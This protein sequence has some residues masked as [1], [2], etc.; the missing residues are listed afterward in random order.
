[1]KET[2]KPAI[3][4]KDYSFWYEH[5]LEPTLEHC[6]FTLNYGE[7]VV[8]AGLSGEGKSTLMFSA[9]GV[10]PNFIPGTQKGDILVQ[11]ESIIGKKIASVAKQVGSVLQNAES[12]I[13]HEKVEDEIAF[14]CEN[15]GIAS[16]NIAERVNYG[17]SLMDLD[18]LEETITL[19]GG[20]KQRLITATT[21]AMAQR[22]VI[23]D[24]PF[25]NID[26]AGAT[27]LL[28]TLRALADK[29]YAVL[30]VEHR[31]DTV[32]PYADRVMW[33]EQRGLRALASGERPDKDLFV[34][35][36]TFDTGSGKTVLRLQDATYTIKEKNILRDLTLAIKDGERIVI[37]GENG[38]GK[39]TLLRL[40]ARLINT[41]SGDYQ[42]HILPDRTKKPK[43]AWFRTVGFVYQNPNYQLFMPT[44]ESE[45]RYQA[46]DDE[47]AQQMLE[48]F[49]LTALS[50]Q[51]P[52]SLSEGQK[53]KLSLAAIMATKPQLLLLDEPTVGQDYGGLAMI[54]HNLELL[55]RETRGAQVVVTHDSRCAK[56]M[57]DRVIWMKQGRIYR[58]GPSSLCDEYFSSFSAQR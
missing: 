8:L 44:V 41:T 55:H 23:L 39:T 5:A 18:P 33:V 24:E 31:L 32:L 25:A 7:M 54:M 28:K 49:G 21:L 20:Q 30:L 1:M 43:P 40:L 53:R 17:C 14:A 6:N 38:C 2:P 58:V 26:A 13:V 52:H 45:V 19:S 29:G 37:V 35:K 22:I 48:A 47:W 27:Q 3:E 4:I 56:A 34:K 51:H 11:G 36:K 57:A 42:Q 10:I 9:N 50:K 46:K 16:E 15:L 12:Q